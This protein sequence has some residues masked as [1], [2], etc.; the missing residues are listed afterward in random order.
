MTTNNFLLLNLVLAFYNVGTI[1]AHE[2]DI[3]RS[4]KL[5]DPKTL[6]MVQVVHWK[7]L[8]YWIFIPV[9]FAFIGSLALFWYHPDNIATWEIWS[10][11]IPQLV[12]H[13]LTAFFWG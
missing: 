13:V 6:H 4:W 3:F 12:S 11:F 5:L 2:I 9:G 10:A 1:W 8:P 7:K